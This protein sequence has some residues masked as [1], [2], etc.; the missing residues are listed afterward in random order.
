MAKK[1]QLDS[2]DLENDDDLE[3]EFNTYLL[4]EEPF[5]LEVSSAHKFAQKKK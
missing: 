3:R 4:F 1:G 5:Y 2:V